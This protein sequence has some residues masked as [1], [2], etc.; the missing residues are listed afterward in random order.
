ML[1]LEE[2]SMSS[3]KLELNK[4]LN[5]YLNKLES[6]GQL[7]KRQKKINIKIIDNNIILD[8]NNIKKEREREKRKSVENFLNKKKFLKSYMDMND[9]SNHLIDKRRNKSIKMGTTNTNH[10]R[11]SSV[12][13]RNRSRSILSSSF[14]E[15]KEK[16]KKYSIK[17]QKKYSEHVNTDRSYIKN[18]SHI[19]N[20]LS[21]C[22]DN[23]KKKN[24]GINKSFMIN[25]NTNRG[26]INN[27]SY[28]R[29]NNRKY[30]DSVNYKNDM[31]ERSII[32]G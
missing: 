26:S 27:D 28:Y 9:I 4:L 32:K 30:E 6:K 11:S 2:M 7:K 14:L 22:M 24:D 15:K 19:N 17:S 23:N 20:K 31:L 12:A 13:N 18:N 3:D 1:T 8:T 16:S 21:I 5:E 29:K 25:D 10:R